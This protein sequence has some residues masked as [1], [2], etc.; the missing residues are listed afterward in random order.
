MLRSKTGARDWRDRNGRS[1]V[2]RWRR[3]GGRLSVYWLCSL[4]PS[5]IGVLRGGMVS[6]RYI[7]A[8]STERLSR[9]LF[10]V[11]G[12]GS[13]YPSTSPV[14]G[15]GRPNILLVEVLVLWFE[16][17]FGD[18]GKMSLTSRSPKSS[19]RFRPARLD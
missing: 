15:R 3:G 16:S 8:G 18:L 2:G 9:R 14:V 5:C 4:I 1:T 11:G 13:G 19:M 17:I 7:G 12:L 10:K 6:L